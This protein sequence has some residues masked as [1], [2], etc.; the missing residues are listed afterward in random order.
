M[1]ILEYIGLDPND[2]CQCEKPE[3]VDYV[4]S[5]TYEVE[6]NRKPT[7]FKC[8]NCGLRI[9][10]DYENSLDAQQPVVET[11]SKDSLLSNAFY[12]EVLQQITPTKIEPYGFNLVFK[13]SPQTRYK[14]I[15]KV[16]ENES[17]S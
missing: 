2:Y 7:I 5:R 9:P 10:P 12:W 15:M 1:T 8:C 17:N 13:Q 14:A 4:V 6:Q 11:L 3:W 16:F